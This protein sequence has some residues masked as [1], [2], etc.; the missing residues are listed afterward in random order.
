MKKQYASEL[1]LLMTAIIWGLAFVAQSA[2]ANVIGPW[3]FICLRN[4]LACIALL[5]V[6]YQYN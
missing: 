4:I 3:S 2:A 1:L 6:V 5:P